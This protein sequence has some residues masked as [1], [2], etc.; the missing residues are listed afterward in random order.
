MIEDILK[1]RLERYR[2]EYREHIQK[3]KPITKAAK[4]RR[5]VMMHEPD[6]MTD[7]EWEAKKSA[8]RF[9]CAYCAGPGPVEMDH[10]IPLSKG[11]RHNPDNVVPACRSCNKSKGDKTLDEWGGVIL[12]PLSRETEE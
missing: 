10:V 9:T 8:Y 11:G 3:G 4:V 5:F 2:Q 6:A 1:E 12:P 7:A